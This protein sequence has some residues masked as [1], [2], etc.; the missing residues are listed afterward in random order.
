V[1]G[2]ESPSEIALSRSKGVTQRALD[3]QDGRV[4]R[5]VDWVNRAF[6]DANAVNGAIAVPKLGDLEA[7]FVNTRRATVKDPE[8]TPPKG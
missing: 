5:I 3:L 2:A 4:M 6:R 8:P 1:E 7:L